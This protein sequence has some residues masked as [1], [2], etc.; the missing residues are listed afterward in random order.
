MVTERKKSNDQGNRVATSLPG[1]LPAH[2]KRKNQNGAEQAP[3]KKRQSSGHQQSKGTKPSV[4][5]GRSPGA[6]ERSSS[7][8]LSTVVCIKIGGSWGE[9]EGYGQSHLSSPRARNRVLTS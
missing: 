6:A 7:P 3:Q 4:K 5:E 1:E 8:G 2:R 9:W